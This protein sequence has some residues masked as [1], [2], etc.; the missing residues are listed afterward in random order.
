MNTTSLFYIFDSYR[1]DLRSLFPNDRL[2]GITRLLGRPELLGNP[3]FRQS[4]SEWRRGV[5]L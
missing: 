4:F 1:S 5:A 3:E 2:P